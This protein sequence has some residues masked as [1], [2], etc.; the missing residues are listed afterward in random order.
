LTSRD[1]AK[2]FTAPGPTSGALPPGHPPV[3]GTGTGTAGAPPREGAAI[4]GTVSVAPALLGR[5]SATD[6]LY[7][8]ARNRASKTVVAVRREDGSKFPR[9]FELS[10]ADAMAKEQPF[11]GPFD[12]TARLSKSGDA[13]PAPGDL[14]GTALNVAEGARGVTVLIEKVRQ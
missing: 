4:S 13:I 5:T 1:E 2:P 12:V 6:V 3:A 10:A 7:L 14:E 11:V 9:A 8:I